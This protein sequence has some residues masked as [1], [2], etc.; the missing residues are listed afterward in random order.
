MIKL[1]ETNNEILKLACPTYLFKK[2]ILNKISDLKQ[3]GRLII[4]T[5]FSSSFQKY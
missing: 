1:N 3:K 5:K 2:I 4:K